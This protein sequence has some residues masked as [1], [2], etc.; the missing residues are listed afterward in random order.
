MISQQIRSLIEADKASYPEARG[1]L[2]GALRRVQEDCGAIT[3]DHA[4]ELAEIFDVRPIEVLELVSFYPMF[5]AEPRGRHQVRVCTNLSCSIAGARD[6]LRALELHL[7]VS[8]G[9]TT[10]DGRI[11]LAS[12]QCLGACANAPT[13]RVNDHD[14][15][16]QTLESALAAL[17]ALE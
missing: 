13:M 7:Q 3:P 8:P 17:D 16:D 10:A 14:H 6:L 1:A 11:T 9:H 15:E 12:E 5:S 4:R 2:L